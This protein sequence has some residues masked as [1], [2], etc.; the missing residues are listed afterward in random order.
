MRSDIQEIM[1]EGLIHIIIPRV[2]Y[3]EEVNMF[4]GCPGDF[5]FLM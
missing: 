4:Y 5:E 1:D 2:E 3:E